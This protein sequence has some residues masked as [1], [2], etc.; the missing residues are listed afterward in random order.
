MLALPLAKPKLNSCGAR[1]I[2]TCQKIRLNFSATR[3]LL[4]VISHCVRLIL[5][6]TFVGLLT[7]WSKRRKELHAMSGRG[8]GQQID[9][10]R[11]E[12][13]GAPSHEL[14]EPRSA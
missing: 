6:T 10:Q 7:S 5:P 12:D 9:R 3:L 11:G 4:C 8:I 2:G 14:R 1:L 13:Q